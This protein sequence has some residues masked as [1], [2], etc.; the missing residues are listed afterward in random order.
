MLAEHLEPITHLAG[1]HILASF[2]YCRRRRPDEMAQQLNEAGLYELVLTLLKVHSQIAGQRNSSTRRDTLDWLEASQGGSPL[3]DDQ[4][5]SWEPKGNLAS[6][7]GSFGASKGNF[8]Q[9]PLRTSFQPD[10]TNQS[11]KLQLTTTQTLPPPNLQS[12]PATTGHSPLLRQ[13]G[14]NA[15]PEEEEAGNGASRG[16]NLEGIKEEDL[17][18]LSGDVT[19]ADQVVLAALEVV[20][21]LASNPHHLQAFRYGLFLSLFFF[22]LSSLHHLPAFKQGFFLFFFPLGFFSSLLV[23]SSGL[24]ATHSLPEITAHTHTPAM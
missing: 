1:L 2:I 4:S 3:P 7:K 16:G 12:L 5:V 24:Q 9:P 23:S 13:N 15:S 17:A 14:G 20:F 11:G 10:S 8:A 18:G 19:L 6:P 21:K 22:L